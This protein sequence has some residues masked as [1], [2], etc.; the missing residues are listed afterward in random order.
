MLEQKIKD[1]LVKLSSVHQIV[2]KHFLDPEH[3]L[4]S[5][6]LTTQGFGDG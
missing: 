5:I 6:S 3:H 1:E 4:V 2:A